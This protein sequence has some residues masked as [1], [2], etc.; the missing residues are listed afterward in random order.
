MSGLLG[1]VCGGVGVG[2]GGRHLWTVVILGLFFKGALSRVDGL[3]AT[4]MAVAEI[5]KKVSKSLIP[6][7]R[8][9]MV[10]EI[11]ERIT[12]TQLE[13]WALLFLYVRYLRC[14]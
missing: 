3:Q 13:W 7:L 11:L 10:H 2:V 8:L 12:E 6:F 1:C 14:N 5:G 9:Y 4:A